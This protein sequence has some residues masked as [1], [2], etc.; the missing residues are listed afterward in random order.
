MPGRIF[1]FHGEVRAPDFSTDEDRLRFILR[2]VCHLL[3][4]RIDGNALQEVCQSL[5]EFY[6]YHRA[7]QVSERL[8]PTARAMNAT[9]DSRSTSPTFLIAEN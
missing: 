4:E 1:C 7:P 2:R 3:I 5:A 9:V 6:E 8:L